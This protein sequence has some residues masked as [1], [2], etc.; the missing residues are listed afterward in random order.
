MKT[1]NELKKTPPSELRDVITSE[2]GTEKIARHMALND[3]YLEK[4]PEVDTLP[5][6]ID[7]ANSVL[8]MY[9]V[10]GS[11]STL[12]LFAIRKLQEAE[13]NLE[14]LERIELDS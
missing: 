7:E 10:Q 4:H 2:V 11:L 8:S 12:L 9:Y 14:R 13:I 6:Y 5:S 1:V 3:V